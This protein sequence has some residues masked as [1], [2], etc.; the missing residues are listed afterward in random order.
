MTR[1]R[2]PLR[3]LQRRWK[4]GWIGDLEAPGARAKATIDMLV[5]DHGLVRKAWRNAYEVEPGVWR[6][7]QPDP[8][9]IRRLATRG[10]KSVLNLRGATEWGSYLLEREACRAAGIELVD[11]KLSSRV[12]PSR[13]EILAL[14]AIFARL[15]RPFLVH[16]KSGADRAGFAA[17]LYLLLRRGAPPA[18]ALGQLHWRYL[19]LR[20][21]ATGVLHFL[22]ERYAAE[23]AR[24]PMSFR[25]WVETRY[26]PAALAAE[27]HGGGA[28]EFLAER[29]L[30]RE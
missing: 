13:A 4:D 19:H 8:A 7:A 25:R 15:P 10:L 28:V 11:F 5:F 1:A 21:A 14:D 6:A 12:P 18:T 17:A 16:C 3:R 26:D 9:M 22:I 2:G 23:S 24:E 30:G 27:Y 29:A 20:G